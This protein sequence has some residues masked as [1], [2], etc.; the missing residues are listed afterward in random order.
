MR[1]FFCRFEH[2][3]VL[4]LKRFFS[5]AMFFYAG[6]LGSLFAQSWSE[7]FENVDSLFTAGWAQQNNSEPTGLGE[8][9]KDNGNFTAQNGTATSSI[10]CDYT[11][12][13]GSGIGNISNWL[14]TP[15]QSFESGDTLFFWTRSYANLYYPDRLEVR[16]SSY[17]TSTDV[18]TDQLSVGL[19]SDLLLSINPTLDTS[20]ANGYPL[21]WKQFA[22]AIPS[23][24]NGLSGRIAFRYFV[25]NGGANGINGSTIGIDNIHYKS[26]NDVSAT[27]E[28]SQ[29][30]WQVYPNPSSGIVTI[31]VDKQLVYTL[32]ATDGK[33]LSSG[34]LIAG[35]NL[36][37]FGN[38]PSGVYLMEIILPTTK[39][40]LVRK[41][42]V[43]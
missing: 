23:S 19:Y 34:K 11:S 9:R 40:R 36:L 20:L 3:T 35:Q 2:L 39:Q 7:G 12:V 1:R 33:K 21:A 29:I 6:V 10:I 30:W 26:A 31:T 4:S 43:H 41:I 32:Y 16:I 18:G 42:Q 25:T 37:D 22:V 17:G 28:Q 24:Y 5:L 15:V 8:W 13:G 38:L 14:F 27:D